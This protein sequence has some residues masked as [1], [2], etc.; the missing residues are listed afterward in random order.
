MNEMSAIYNSL[1]E[2]LEER[3]MIV[4]EKEN[5]DFDIRDYIADSIHFI[6]FIVQVEERFKIELSDEFS[7][8]DVLAS[9]K[10]FTNKLL[11]QIN[12]NYHDYDNK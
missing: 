5:D 6:E 12:K 2:I 8:Y 7:L 9:A 3:G 1:I 10:G 11:D 4:F